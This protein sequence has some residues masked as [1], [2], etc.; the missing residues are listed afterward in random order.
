M[1][2]TPG[3][4]I[5]PAAILLI[6]I[7]V[8]ITGCAGTAYNSGVQEKAPGTYF[9]SVRS[10]TSNGGCCLSSAESKRVAVAQADEY[11]GWSGKKAQVASEELGPVTADIYFTCV[12]K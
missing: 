12:E 8:V 11:C 9:L 4:R 2:L 1:P 5:R 10:A 7:S 3:L 6:A